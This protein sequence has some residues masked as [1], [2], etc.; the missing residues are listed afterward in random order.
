MPPGLRGAVGVPD[1]SWSFQAGGDCDLGGRFAPDNVRGRLQPQIISFPQAAAMTAEE[2]AGRGVCRSRSDTDPSLKRTFDAL[3]SPGGR[4]RRSDLLGDACCGS[5]GRFLTPRVAP[6]CAGRNR[7]AFQ[8]ETLRAIL[9]KAFRLVEGRCDHDV[10]RD[11]GGNCRLG[12]I[13]VREPRFL[14][15][16]ARC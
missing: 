13:G 12:A 8:G 9:L 14:P 1:P 15:R 7:H 16:R 5:C 2:S 11:R 3:E 10:G 6:N 4:R